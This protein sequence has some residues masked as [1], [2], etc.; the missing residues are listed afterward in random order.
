MEV[1]ERNQQTHLKS[2]AFSISPSPFP[3]TGRLHDLKEVPYLAENYC[4]E[5]LWPIKQAN[6]PL[7]PFTFTLLNKLWPDLWKKT[8]DLPVPFIRLNIPPTAQAPGLGY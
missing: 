7:A 5:N 1:S 8:L 4:Q 3:H 6:V 2:Q